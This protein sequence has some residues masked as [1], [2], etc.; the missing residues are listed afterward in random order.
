MK[1]EDADKLRAAIAAGALAKGL[2]DQGQ[3]Q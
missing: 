3:S 1:Q 2:A